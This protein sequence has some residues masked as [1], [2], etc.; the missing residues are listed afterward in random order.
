MFR[1][2]LPWRIFFIFLFS[3]VTKTRR[4]AFQPMNP[5]HIDIVLLKIRLWLIQKGFLVEHNFKTFRHY[6][7][8]L[9][10]LEILTPPLCTREFLSTQILLTTHQRNFTFVWEMN[11]YE[12]LSESWPLFQL[13]LASF[14]KGSK[15]F[16]S[17]LQSLIKKTFTSGGTLRESWSKHI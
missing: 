14:T 7:K 2:F 5:A 4:I 10:E 3:F 16:Y 11:W 6:Y 12:S 13:L 17:W 8:H 9:W 1:T 15:H